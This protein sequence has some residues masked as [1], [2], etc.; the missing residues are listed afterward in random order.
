MLC[1]CIDFTLLRLPAFSQG[2]QLLRSVAGVATR[3]VALLQHYPTCSSG[4]ARSVCMVKVFTATVT[5]MFTCHNQDWLLLSSGALDVLH[6]AL[7]QHPQSHH[8]GVVGCLLELY[9]TI[10]S[11]FARLLT[12][13][14]EVGCRIVDSG[15]CP[16]RAACLKRLRVRRCACD[17][18]T[19]GLNESCHRHCISRSCRPLHRSKL[20]V[21]LLRSLAN[22][23]G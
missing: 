5:V 1:W 8:A 22:P 4:F 15:P 7:R 2:W 9:A 11:R 13:I 16:D 12:A 21:S 23:G 14:P 20:G 17:F 19:T 10:Q 18:V 3:G 6:E